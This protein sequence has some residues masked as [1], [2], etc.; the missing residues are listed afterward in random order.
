MLRNEQHQLAKML[1]MLAECG[2]QRLTIKHCLQDCPQWRDS[3]R[4][5]IIQG[6][7]RALLGMNC[8][9]EKIMRCFKE[10]EMFEEI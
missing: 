2:D 5:Y 10:T 7:L 4:K 3:R 6:D 9:V 8:E 1:E